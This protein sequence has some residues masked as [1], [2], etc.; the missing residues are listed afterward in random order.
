MLSLFLP[1]GDLLLGLGSTLAPLFVGILVALIVA[2]S[3]KTYA[4]ILGWVA[5]VVMLTITVMGFIPV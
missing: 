3:E 5:V 1:Q 2:A 4:R